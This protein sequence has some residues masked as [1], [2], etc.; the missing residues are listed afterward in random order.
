MEGQRLLYVDFDVFWVPLLASLGQDQHSV[1]V[2]EVQEEL[3]NFLECCPEVS[4]AV[5]LFREKE[6]ES[7][8]YK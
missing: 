3:F 4:Y 8:K 1:V 7:F 2:L 6:R 5:Y